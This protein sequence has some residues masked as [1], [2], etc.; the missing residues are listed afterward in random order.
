MKLLKIRN[1]IESNLK[2]G[3]G[4]LQDV[5][6]NDYSFYGSIKSNNDLKSN[7]SGILLN[8]SAGYLPIVLDY[9][10]IFNYKDV[11]EDLI[12]LTAKKVMNYI[13]LI[14]QLLCFPHNESYYE[15]PRPEGRG[16]R[17]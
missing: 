7:L 5:S 10:E 6:I 2:T 8:I 17:V 9:E 11:N 4:N 15:L 13:Y 12:S 16:F 14:N 1:A 3:Y